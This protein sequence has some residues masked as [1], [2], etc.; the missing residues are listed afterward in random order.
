MQPTTGGFADVLTMTFPTANILEAERD[1]AAPALAE[2][3]D[4]AKA[5]GRLRNDFARQSEAPYRGRSVTTPSNDQRR[6]RQNTLDGL[7]VRCRADGP[8]A[9]LVGGAPLEIDTRFFPAGQ[10]GNW[11][12]GLSITHTDT[13]GAANVKWSYYAPSLVVMH[14]AHVEAVERG[15]RFRPR[16]R[17]SGGRAVSGR[18]SCGR[19][20]GA[21]P[22]GPARGRQSGG[23]SLSASRMALSAVSKSDCCDGVR[24]RVVRR[25]SSCHAARARGTAAAP[26]SVS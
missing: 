16:S 4:C 21:P 19:W 6:P 14:E 10:F 20:C 24:E 18:S 26:L 11:I 2:V 25:S 7:G 15:S 22:L 17:P 23:S 12:D 5:T 13:R 9:C 3:L 8:G 1:C